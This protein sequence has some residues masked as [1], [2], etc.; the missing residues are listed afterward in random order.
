MLVKIKPEVQ[1]E[2]QRLRELLEV[3]E[4]NAEIIRKKL[5]L[6]ITKTTES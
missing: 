4:R 2:I 6:L 5:S 1:A 3:H